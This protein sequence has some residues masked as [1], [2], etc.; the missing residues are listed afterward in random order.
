[1]VEKE[2]IKR[3]DASVRFHQCYQQLEGGEFCRSAKQ[4]TVILLNQDPKFPD[5]LRHCTMSILLYLC[6][7]AHDYNLN[8]H[9]VEI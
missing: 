3:G 1:M 6:V 4:V 2:S 8:I 7:D 9:G 5:V